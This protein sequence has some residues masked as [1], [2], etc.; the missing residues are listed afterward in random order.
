MWDLKGSNFS[1]PNIIYDHEEE[2]VTASASEGQLASMD[3]EGTVLIREMSGGGSVADV[4]QTLRVNRSAC[5]DYETGFILYNIK[6]H[7]EL[8][9]FFNM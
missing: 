7:K 2:I 9:V 5:G 4:L 1:K 3:T 8:F 6:V